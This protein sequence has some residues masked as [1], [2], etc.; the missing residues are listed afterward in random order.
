[1]VFSIFKNISPY[2]FENYTNTMYSKNQILDPITM[3]IRV[4]LLELKPTYTKLSLSNNRIYFQEPWLFQGTLRKIY[5]DKKSDVNVLIQCIDR[6][7]LWY[8]VNNE[9]IKYICTRMITGLH[10]LSACYRDSDDNLVCQTIAFVIGKI[11]NEMENCE[12]DADDILADIDDDDKDQQ[13]YF[14]EHWN[15]RE[16]NIIYNL[17]KEL[18]LD[19]RTQKQESILRS[20]DDLISYK[21]TETHSYVKKLVKY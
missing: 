6:L 15:E 7:L 20:V 11:E 1:M 9:Q 8:N 16:I 4:G 21:D 18:E 2:I 19:T 17:L 10:Q 5:G 13:K 12:F 3:A 14:R